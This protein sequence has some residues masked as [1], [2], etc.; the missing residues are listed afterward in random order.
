MTAQITTLTI[1]DGA[2]A[3]R[4]VQAVDLSGTGAGPWSFLHGLVDRAGNPYGPTNPLVIAGSA[5]VGSAPTNPP[6][7]VSGIDPAGLKRHLRTDVSGNLAVQNAPLKLRDQFETDMIGSNWT[8]TADPSDLVFYDGNALGAG[9]L[10]ISKD[11]MAVGTETVVESIPTFAAPFRAGFGVSLSQRIVGQPCAIEVVS[12]DA[13]IAAVADATIA[14]ISQATTTL[15]VTTTAAHGL[16]PGDRVSIDGV[17][18][19]NALNYPQLVVATVPSTTQF[20]A[21]AYPGGTIPSLT[22]GPYTTGTVRRLDHLGRAADGSALVFEGASTTTATLAARTGGTPGAVTS[23]TVDGNQLTAVLSSASVQALVAA[24]VYAF[25]PTTLYELVQQAEAVEWLNIASDVS[26]STLTPIFNRNQIVPD[27]SK[28][29]RVRYRAANT[30]ALA[31]PVA[32]I[33]SAV[34]SGTTTATI[35]TDRAH[36]LATGETVTLY[37]IRDTANFANLTSATAVTVVDATHFTIP[38]GSAATATSYGGVVCRAGGGRVQGGIASMVVQSA[39]TDAAGRLTLVGSA[40]WSGP[41]IGDTVSLYGL[42]SAADG[43]SLGL[44]GVWRVADG[45]G[46]TSLVLEPIGATVA[47]ANL[48]SVNC[49]GAAI[50]RTDMR[51]HFV[52]VAEITRLVTET[53]GGMARNDMSKAQQVFTVGTGTMQGAQGEQASTN[54]NG[55]PA[56]VATY[57]TQPTAGTN[58]RRSTIQGDRAARPVVRPLGMPQ[59]NAYGRA[60]LTTTSETQLLAATASNRWELDNVVV[61]NRDTVAH[62]VDVRD[63]LAGTVRWSLVVPAGVTCHLPLRGAP[64][65][66][67]N[68]AVTAALREAATTAVEV[69]VNAYQTTA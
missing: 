2:G 59:A 62:T 13:A 14:S 53:M 26:N 36:G 4:T 66:A 1:K 3:D 50:K 52:R 63:A 16:R 49:G 21:S 20:T 30:P 43:S 54:Y 60:S 5:A 45:V 22:A 47:P 65:T 48:A 35:T 32:G 46:T 33:V 6:L 57:D 44:D 9:Y 12:T 56:M 42:R 34:K 10:V 18:A 55:I 69:S 17:V 61:A 39:A 38:L 29:Y 23:G 51:L 27:P 37:G 28:R 58:G 31:R 64:A 68:A 19:A 11:P 67:A 15:T 8:V 24:G 40:A 7:A 25:A 41:V